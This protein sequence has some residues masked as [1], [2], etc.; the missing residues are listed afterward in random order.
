MNENDYKRFVDGFEPDNKLKS[1]LHAN[2]C[3]PPERNITRGIAIVFATLALLL[4][5]YAF[6]QTAI[7]NAVEPNEP[8]T[9]S[10]ITIGDPVSRLSDEDRLH[11]YEYDG[12]LYEDYETGGFYYK[13]T[14][15]MNE[16]ELDLLNSSSDDFDA[17]NYLKPI[18][19]EMTSW[20]YYEM[21]VMLQRYGYDMDFEY[22]RNFEKSEDKLKIKIPIIKVHSF[23]DFVIE[24]KEQCTAGEVEPVTWR[25]FYVEVFAPDPIRTPNNSTNSINEIILRSKPIKFYNYEATEDEKSIDA[26]FHPQLPETDEAAALYLDL[27]RELEALGLPE[28]TLEYTKS[29]NGLGVYK[30]FIEC[31]NYLESD[32]LLKFLKP[33]RS[34]PH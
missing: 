33:Y 13:I 9:F 4:I 1:R 29:E 34:D 30:L 10:N 28:C 14:R 20:L 2:L 27:A 25:D 23:V 26:Y 19:S 32:T 31:D 15:Y 11:W 12:M 6:F 22:Y 24:L 5:S 21:L 8:Y 18:E 7:T 3:R 16:E 17:N